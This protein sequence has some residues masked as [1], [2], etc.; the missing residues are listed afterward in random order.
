MSSLGEPR[1][2]Y[3]PRREAFMVVYKDEERREFDLDGESTDLPLQWNAKLAKPPVRARVDRLPGGYRLVCMPGVEVKVNGRIV[4]GQHVLRGGDE[5]QFDR[6]NGVFTT[7]REELPW[8]MT[9]VVWPPE[10]PA[11]EVRTHRT[12]ID[13]GVSLGDVVVEDPTLDGLHCTVTRFRNGIMRITDHGTYNGVYVDGI[14]VVESMGLRDGAE[15]RIG[16]TRMKAWAEAPD[17]PDFASADEPVQDAF[18]GLP[19]GGYDP[20]APEAQPLRPYAIEVGPEFVQR[21]RRTLDDDVPTKPDIESQHVDVRPRLRPSEHRG[22]AD[23]TPEDEA[24][25]RLV[26]W[27]PNAKNQ[28]Q[29]R[30]GPKRPSRFEDED[31]DDWELRDKAGLTLVHKKDRPILPRSGK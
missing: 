30:S 20:D 18:D 16:N 1:A 27:A 23:G 26:S 2:R 29:P 24:E 31:G 22:Y 8:P 14:K 17:V 28:P 7:A 12:R 25:Q 5:I 19:Y 4:E 13:I 9:L 21:K 10:G 6:F 3:R 11:V 15:I